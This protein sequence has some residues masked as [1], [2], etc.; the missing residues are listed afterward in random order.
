MLQ[1]RLKEAHS[2]AL[3]ALTALVQ[4]LVSD[5]SPHFLPESD[6]V[7]LQAFKALQNVIGGL[8]AALPEDNDD[9]SLIVTHSVAF[10]LFRLEKPSPS[11]ADC[12]LA[13][14]AMAC[15]EELLPRPRSKPA[16]LRMIHAMLCSL[17]P[18]CEKWAE[19]RRLFRTGDVAALGD[20]EGDRLAVVGLVRLLCQVLQQMDRIATH[21][22]LLAQVLS[23]MEAA[24]NVLIAAG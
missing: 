16:T 17:H 10:C 6:G 21:K 1:P 12:T 24:M 8:A 23:A 4:R 2:V 11:E 7:I 19:R 22:P 14:A 5:T 3:N 9:I 13:T 18:T 20:E 15:I